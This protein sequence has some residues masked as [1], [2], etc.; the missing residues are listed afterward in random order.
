MSSDSANQ[1]LNQYRENT[2]SLFDEFLKEKTKQANSIGKVP[3]QLVKKFADIAKRGK[4][5]RGAL[6]TLGYEVAGGRNKRA[7][8]D[9]SIFIELFHTGVLVHDDL[10]DQDKLRRGQ[11][12]IHLQFA[13]YGNR[14]KAKPSSEHFA[15]SM[16]I[17]SGDFAF[18]L[19]WE[20]LLTSKFP[21]K[22]LFKAANIY[23]NTALRLVHG[24]VLDIS[25][26]SIQL[27]KQ[28]D[29]LKMIQLKTAEYTGVLP[30]IIGATLADLKDN[31]K[32]QAIKNYGLALGWAFQIQ[33]D[34]LGM[35][36]DKKITG[37]PIGSD[38]REG[39]ITL[40]MLHLAKYGNK[41]QKAFQKKTLGNP[42]INKVEILKMQQI[43]I[44]A[45]SFNYVKK[46]GEQYVKNGKRAIKTLTNNQVHS[47]LLSSLLIYILERSK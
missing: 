47:E 21:Q 39:K 6:V 29:I 10:M 46:L 1:Y 20:K 11:P 7:I 42:R 32:L 27:A 4:R 38:L 36:T 14:I 16:A 2:N 35:F 23:T 30:L 31:K 13:E 37:K 44:E 26:T 24:Q 25:N 9:A 45:G 18:Y 19:S 33:D 41:Q 17:S 22:L 40:L 5:I 3:T 15:R 12:T 8:L 28:K 43:L 34:I